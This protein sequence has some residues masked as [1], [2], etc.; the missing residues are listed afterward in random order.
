VAK[1]KNLLSPQAPNSSSFWRCLYFSG[2]ISIF[3]YFLSENHAFSRSYQACDSSKIGTSKWGSSSSEQLITSEFALEQPALSCYLH[4]GTPSC[5]NLTRNRLHLLGHFVIRAIL[6]F[7]IYPGRVS[8]F[9]VRIPFPCLIILFWSY[10]PARCSFLDG[11][12]LT[13]LT[14]CLPFVFRSSCHPAILN[15]GIR[16][17]QSVPLRCVSGFACFARYCLIV[18]PG[19]RCY[20]L[21]GFFF[22]HVSKRRYLLSLVRLVVR[23]FFQRDTSRSLIDN[24]L[25]F[26]FVSSFGDFSCGSFLALGLG[27]KKS[28]H[29]VLVRNWETKSVKSCTRFTVGIG[30]REIPLPAAFSIELR[31]AK[32]E[33][34]LREVILTDTS[35]FTIRKTKRILSGGDQASLACIELDLDDSCFV[36]AR[37]FIPQSFIL[38]GLKS[39][40]CL[41]PNLASLRSRPLPPVFLF[42]LRCCRGWPCCRSLVEQRGMVFFAR[43]LGGGEQK[44]SG[45][46]LT[47]KDVGKRRGRLNRHVPACEGDPS[48]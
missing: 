44:A 45:L 8:T 19:Y 42:C 27:G 10:L 39:F 14:Y 33:Y 21:D 16:H 35:A 30:R 46:Y 11:S 6:H 7:G 26:F 34:P 31:E 18:S 2:Y 12:S 25:R 1:S 5:R 23:R 22:D 20:V 38:R 29:H 13:M 32:S 3:A 36:H 37:E 40:E 15:V 28:D 9:L 17:R 24:F 43:E 4:P 48:L 41:F 47:L